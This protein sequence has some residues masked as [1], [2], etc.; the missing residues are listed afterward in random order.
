LHLETFVLELDK[1]MS[2]VPLLEGFEARLN[3]EG[4]LEVDVRSEQNINDL[5]SKLDSLSI[6]VRS[7]RNKA[8]RLEEL[9]LDL[10]ENAKTQEEV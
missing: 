5:F 4:L 2:T 6:Q 3:E 10:V 7:M 8:N 9:F 1:P